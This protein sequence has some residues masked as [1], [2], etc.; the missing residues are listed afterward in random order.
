MNRLEALRLLVG[1]SVMLA[2]AAHSTLAEASCSDG[3]ESGFSP[4]ASCWCDSQCQGYGDCCVD[5]AAQCLAPPAPKCSSGRRSWGGSTELQAQ[6]PFADLQRTHPDIGLAA[7]GTG[8][9][10]WQ[11]HDPAP[12]GFRGVRARRFSGGAWSAAVNL[13]TG[14]A[15][16]W[17][18]IARVAVGPNGH[19]FV[20]LPTGDMKRFL[21]LSGWSSLS[22]S[23]FDAT[24]TSLE[25]GV[26]GAGSLVYLYASAGLLKVRRFASIWEAP[27]SLGAP[28]PSPDLA[29]NAAGMSA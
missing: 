28:T 21:P 16:S 18:T 6:P 20:T 14:T 22:T 23:G 12:G 11:T 27:D 15:T 1:G 25:R 24:R 5:Y 4:E 7:D 26:D 29:V 19:A 8:I 10:V 17:S 2:S 3:C 13:G 9:A